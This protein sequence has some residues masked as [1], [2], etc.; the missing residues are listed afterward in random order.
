MANYNSFQVVESFT[1]EVDLNSY[2]Y[3]FVKS[4]SVT[5][6]QVAPATTAAGSVLGVLINDPKAGEEASVVMM[7]WTK[8]KANTESGA[9]PLTM[10]GFIKSGSRGEATGM[11]NAA[12]STFAQGMAMEALT[13]GC[14]VYVNVLV[15]PP[16]YRA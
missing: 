8:M 11:A 3:C 6:G 14:G 9:S 12:A 7:G 16:V 2:Q 1:A 10:H 13:T 15:L 5:S 4:S